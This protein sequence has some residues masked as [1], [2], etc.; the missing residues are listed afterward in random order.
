[1]DP[2]HRTGIAL[3]VLAGIASFVV[4]RMAAVVMVPWISGIAGLSAVI[5]V[6]NWIDY[7]TDVRRV[8]HNDYDR[9]PRDVFAVSF[10]ALALGFIGPVLWWLT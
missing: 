9:K 1:M 10:T 4:V 8:N 7:A 3:F 2:T 6:M 5:A